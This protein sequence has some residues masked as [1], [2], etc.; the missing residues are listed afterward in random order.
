MTADIVPFQFEEHSI[1]VR[2]RDGQP[3]FVLTDV[4]RVLELANAS[5]AAGRLDEDERGIVYADTLGG[6]Q[7][8]IAINESGLWKLVL[9]SKKQSARR[10][11]KWL[12]SEV[13][14]AIRRTGQYGAPA[15]PVDLN[16]PATLRRL[17]LD[18]TGHTLALQQRLDHLEPQAAALERL[19][20]A[21]GS[22]CITDAAK[23]LSMRPKDL[24]SWLERESWIYRRP[25]GSRW[26]G[27]QARVKSGVLEHRLSRLDR[28]PAET[29]K[30]VEQVLITPRGLAKIA[31]D[32]HVHA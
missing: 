8:M 23:A 6:S 2:D 13:L 3:W 17:L 11:T 4:C 15:A 24:F 16:D 9:R 10:F 31:A 32:L 22:L 28:G 1:R 25:Q 12:T 30:L 5:D 18:H 7:R 21:E 29:P 19:T 14:P 26:M 27:Y 20:S